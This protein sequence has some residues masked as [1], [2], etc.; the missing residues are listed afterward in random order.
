MPNYLLFCLPSPFHLLCLWFLRDSSFT[1]SQSCSF[2]IY[3]FLRDSFTFILISCHLIIIYYKQHFK[4]SSVLSTKYV[5]KL[6]MFY[7]ILLIMISTEWIGRGSSE[8]MDGTSVTIYIYLGG[9]TLIT[10]IYVMFMHH[11]CR[12]DIC[13]TKCI[14]V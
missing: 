5:S 4:C 12:N 2:C 10:Y 7:F 1:P 3:R 6:F 14:Y 9:V 8:I 11:V 13:T